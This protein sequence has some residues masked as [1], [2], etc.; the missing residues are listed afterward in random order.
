[1]LLVLM[2]GLGRRSEA[3]G[4]IMEMILRCEKAPDLQLAAEAVS[5]MLTW[6]H[7]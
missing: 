7:Q 1:V 3:D 6:S 5:S 2:D 4:R